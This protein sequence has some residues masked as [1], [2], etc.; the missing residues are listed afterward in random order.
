[1]NTPKLVNVDIEELLTQSRKHVQEAPIVKWGRIVTEGRATNLTGEFYDV[2]VMEKTV[3]N[4]L[5]PVP[6]GFCHESVPGD[7]RFGAVT[8]L[9]RLNNEVYARFEINP[10]AWTWI[11]DLVS[12]AGGNRIELSQSTWIVDKSLNEV[13]FV[14]KGA[15]E[16]CYI[17]DDYETQAML[18][19]AREE[20]V[21][22][23]Q[24]NPTN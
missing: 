12:K 16:R 10:F 9:F 4:T 11:N 17:L 3:Q 20:G 5:L 19:K 23:D 21:I 8:Q 6:I 7:R 13:S 24:E 1:M 15:L 2:P 14:E 22:D 18:A